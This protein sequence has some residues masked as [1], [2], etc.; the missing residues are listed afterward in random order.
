MITLSQV[1]AM[2]KSELPDAVVK[3]EDLGG[4]DHLQAVVVSPLFEGKTLVKQHQMV[5][6]AVREAMATEAIH[7][8]AL[9]TYTPQ[10][11][12]KVNQAA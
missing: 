9:K 8:L 5:Y 2:I 12:S 11:W 7:A 3:V 1:E 6:K 4:G 10:E